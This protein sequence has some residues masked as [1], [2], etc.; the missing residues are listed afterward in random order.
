ML[1]YNKKEAEAAID[2]LHRRNSWKSEYLKFKEALIKKKEKIF[3][4]P[5]KWELPD[6]EKYKKLEKNQLMKCILPNETKEEEKMK[7]W[8]GYINKQT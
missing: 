3:E 5:Y 6:V 2:M 4:D 1:R 7:L 8:L